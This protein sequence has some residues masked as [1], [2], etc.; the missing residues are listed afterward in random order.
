MIDRVKEGSGYLWS[1][2]NIT[3]KIKLLCKIRSK[4]EKKESSGKTKKTS[5]NWLKWD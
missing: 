1:K 5:E 3:I 4:K 2:S